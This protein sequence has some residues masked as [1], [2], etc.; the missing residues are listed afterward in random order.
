MV[1]MG[2]TDLEMNRRA[3]RET[4]GKMQAA[5]D[6]II[7]PNASVSQESGSNQSLN[8]LLEMGFSQADAERAFRKSN[9][10]LDQAAN[11]LLMEEQF[12]KPTVVNDEIIPGRDIMFRKQQN[13]S[14]QHAMN[15]FHAGIH[16]QISNED[17]YGVFS[18]VDPKS[19]SVFQIHSSNQYEKRGEGKDRNPF[20]DAIDEFDPFS[21]QNRV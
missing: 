1:S 2:F 7:N 6:L 11:L 9:G 19:S 16:S 3:L 10:N 17:K 12:S 15:D 20:E 5:I 8:P 4:N 21:D 18:G 14:S 13:I